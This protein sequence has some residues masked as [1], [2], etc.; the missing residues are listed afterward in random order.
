MIKKIIMKNFI[1]NNYHKHIGLG[2]LIG[3]VV[4]IVL[5]LFS[6]D[7]ASIN[8]VCGL[9]VGL[10]AGAVWEGEQ[11]YRY[12]HVEWDWW[13]VVYSAVGS[14]FGSLIITLIF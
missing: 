12:Q 10:I 1:Q 14:L 9:I 11:T 7:N 3:I 8:L 4:S 13:D 2:I 5:H 6:Y